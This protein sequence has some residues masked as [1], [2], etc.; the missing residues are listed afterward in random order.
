MFFF[1]FDKYSLPVLIETPQFARSNQTRMSSLPIPHTNYSGSYPET[2]T[3]ILRLIC[4]LISQLSPRT[5]PELTRDLCYQCDKRGDSL[6]STII[7]KLD[8]QLSPFD[9]IIIGYERGRR[10]LNRYLIACRISTIRAMLYWSCVYWSCLLLLAWG[11]I[12]SL[13]YVVFVNA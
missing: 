6:A 4:F 7:N 13:A 3:A 12:G 8:T 9:P 5:Q 1:V 2:P 10:L 11:F